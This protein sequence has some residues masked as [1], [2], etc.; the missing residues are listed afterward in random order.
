MG[1]ES[2]S[3]STIA[4]QE[5]QR[6]RGGREGETPVTTRICIRR[7]SGRSKVQV[8]V[9]TVGLALKREY[10][11]ARVLY[12]LRSACLRGLPSP[13]SP[14]MRTERMAH[15]A[16]MELDEP[17]WTTAWWT[18]ADLND[19]LSTRDVISV[20]RDRETEGGRW[21]W[22]DKNR[23]GRGRR[24]DTQRQTAVCS[25]VIW[26]CSRLQRGSLARRN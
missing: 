11:N 25:D 7:Q 17:R 23:K 18:A 4:N 3:S 14:W 9:S 16:M 13:G 2:F 24:K 10:S 22:R 5:R 1:D 19:A 21:G 12:A 20:A 6:E 15:E 8:Q 26:A